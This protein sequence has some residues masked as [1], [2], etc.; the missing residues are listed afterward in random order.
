MKGP[1][2]AL[3]PAC[4]PLA[5]C[6]PLAIRSLPAPSAGRYPAIARNL[7]FPTLAPP[8]RR[9]FVEVIRSQSRSALFGM[10]PA[11]NGDWSPPHSPGSSTPVVERSDLLRSHSQ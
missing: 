10:P 1:L 2:P 7:R 4:F 6:P 11:H 3:A 9:F 5:C 8:P